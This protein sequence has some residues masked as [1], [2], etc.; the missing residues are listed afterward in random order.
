MEIVRCRLAEKNI[1]KG[2]SLEAGMQTLKGNLWYSVV[3][4]EK[5]LRAKVYQN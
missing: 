2:Q 4:D 5:S 1:R 3:S